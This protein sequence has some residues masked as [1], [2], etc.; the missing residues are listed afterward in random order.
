MH[1][2]G[3]LL[4][5]ETMQLLEQSGQGKVLG[6]Y[7]HCFN[8]RL[9]DS[10]VTIFPEGSD[11]IPGG[12]YTDH[13][14]STDFRSLSLAT[15]QH[16]FTRDQYIWIPEA[17]YTCCVVD[18]AATVNMARSPIVWDGSFAA[19][20][21]TVEHLSI[22]VNERNSLSLPPIGQWLDEQSQPECEILGKLFFSNLKELLEALS[23]QDKDTAFQQFHKLVGRGIGLTP[24][25]D[26]ILCGM[27]SW[28]YLADPVNRVGLSLRDYLWQYLRE[29]GFARTTF[30][31]GFF[32]QMACGG[33]ISDSTYL[34]VK[35]MLHR[36][37]DI[38]ANAH[39]LLRHGSTSGSEIC[40][41]IITGW[42]MSKN[43]L[44]QENQSRG[45]V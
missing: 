19:L 11:C 24:S 43:A 26:D 38:S 8:M 1:C 3:R 30:V 32:L 18:A 16:V 29:E 39:R 4:E 7:R 45:E 6:V 41:G 35:G 12:I 42:W 15:G 13:P 28:F 40:F 9:E 23:R 37:W 17:D 22:M 34:L 25:A 31:S 2:N 21:D 14:P 33:V 44:S 10:L 36:E 27:I 20:E 5:K